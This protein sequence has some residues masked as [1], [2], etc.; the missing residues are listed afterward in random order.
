MSGLRRPG[1][2]RRRIACGLVAAALVA[3]G[4]SSDGDTTE[5][6]EVSETDGTEAPTAAEPAT[7]DA[8]AGRSSEARAY[9]SAFRGRRT[10]SGPMISYL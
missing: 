2:T 1:A 7:T 9:G 3:A 5:S 8:V 6:T 4:C 10:P